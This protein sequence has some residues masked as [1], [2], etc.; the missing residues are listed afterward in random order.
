MQ[1]EKIKNIPNQ[2]MGKIYRHWDHVTCMYGKSGLLASRTDKKGNIIQLLI[3]NNG[4]KRQLFKNNEEIIDEIDINGVKRTFVYEKQADGTTIGAMRIT[5]NISDNKKPL[6]ILAKWISENLRPLIAELSLN[7]RHPNSMM[8]INETVTNGKVIKRYQ[9]R[10]T[11]V[12]FENFDN[13]TIRTPLPSKVSMKT[14]KGET[15][16]VAET[17][18]E[19]KPY[20]RQLNLHDGQPSI[21]QM[22]VI[23]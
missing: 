12:I 21:E 7:T 20:V 15:K 16:T 14:A 18:D 13:Q 10:I 8:T 3:T 17:I 2:Y 1:V 11:H 4:K 19:S 23:V 6:V 9:E 22:R 5:N